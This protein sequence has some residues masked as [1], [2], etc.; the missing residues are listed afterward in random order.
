METDDN[1]TQNYF[2]FTNYKFGSFTAIFCVLTVFTSRSSSP[3]SPKHQSFVKECAV[4]FECACLV[5][6][7]EL[8]VF[9]IQ[10]FVGGLVMLF[11]AQK[12]KQLMELCMWITLIARGFILL[13][14]CRH[15]FLILLSRLSPLSSL[16]C[17]C[18]IH[19]LLWDFEEHQK[20]TK[21][22]F[23]LPHPSAQN[24]K[25]AEYLV[26]RMFVNNSNFPH[27]AWSFP[28]WIVI[29]NLMY[30]RIYRT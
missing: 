14:H 23:L 21:I 22:H 19:Y 6:F 16:L 5:C 17:R 30:L 1:S 18:L 4:R 15:C 3:T 29:T 11:K 7:V 9:C 28:R 2:H 12:Q 26:V 25:H 24:K 8:V 13:T 10:L 27:W 20:S